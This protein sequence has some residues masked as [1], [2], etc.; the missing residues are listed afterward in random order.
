MSVT[1]VSEYLP[2]E[3]LDQFLAA[4]QDFDQSFVDALVSGVDFTIKLEVRGD[5]GK[6]LHAKIDE[7]RFR[8]PAGVKQEVDMG[9]RSRR[10]S[11]ISSK[12]H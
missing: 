7:G 5:A 12:F 2:D 1:K 4:M 9:K 6:L 10:N 11:G 3:S 8:R